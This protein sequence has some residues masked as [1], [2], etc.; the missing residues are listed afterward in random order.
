MRHSLR[1]ALVVTWTASLIFT[2]DGWNSALAQETL[3][4]GYSPL[5]AAPFYFAR[6][7]EYLGSGQAVIENRDAHRTLPSA[8]TGPDPELVRHGSG[9][10]TA[11]G[12]ESEDPEIEQTQFQSGR[13]RTAR[14]GSAPLSRPALSS[15]ARRSRDLVRSG[16]STSGLRAAARTSGTDRISGRESTFRATTDAGSLLGRS[17]RSRNISTQQRNP[18]IND[19]R[20]RGTRTGQLLA[21]GSFWVPA[22]VDL[23]TMLSKLDSRV[24]DDI[25]VIKGPYSALYGPGLSFIDID[26]T[27]SRRSETGVESG[28]M[29]SL[30]Y[31]TN[32]E[33]WYGRQE[34]WVAG[35]NSGAT[36]SYGHR[37]G[38][39]YS[40]GSSSER[41]PSSYNS[42]DVN[43]AAGVDLDERRSLEF[44][45]IR[46]DQTDVDLAGQIF[47]IDTLETD[48]FEL[49]YTAG[50]GDWY[51]S[52]F[53][54]TW[55]NQ[56]NFQGR[57]NAA[58]AER[59]TPLFNRASFNPDSRTLVN[60]QS[61]GYRTGLNWE[62]D[63]A[64]LTVG[65]DLRFIRQHLDEFT[66]FVAVQNNMPVDPN[67]PVPKSNQL[68]P[69]LFVEASLGTSSATTWT[70]GARADWVRYNLLDSPEGDFGNNGLTLRQ[71]LSGVDSILTG[72]VNNQIGGNIVD[73]NLVEE[74][75]PN[76]VLWSTYLTGTTDHGNGVTTFASAGIGQRPP[77]LTELY[78]DEPF[79]FLVQ[80]G[81]TALRGNPRLKPSTGFQFDIGASIEQPNYRT[82]V[83]GFYSLIEDYITFDSELVLISSTLGFQNVLRSVNSDLAAIGGLELD[84]D[85]D[86]NE[87]VTAFGT[88]A[89]THGTD[90]RRNA[91]NRD[92]TSTLAP[93]T[94]TLPI[95]T[96]TT[97]IVPIGPF[98]VPQ[99]TVVVANKKHEPLPAISPLAARLGLRLHE[100]VEQPRY[101]VELAARVVTAQERVAAS[102]F[103]TPTPG[104]T[105]WDL[106][107]FWRPTPSVLLVAGVE[108]LTDKGYREHLDFRDFLE[109]I[110]VRRPG[111]SYYSSV[112][113]RY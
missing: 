2:G 66:Q 86:V 95:G 106:R 34:L 18:V 97:T 57:A 90:L 79:L 103:E 109:N 110:E 38:S 81:L 21:S 56:T 93:G 42:R 4:P 64:V 17:A 100:P 88:L 11:H 105:V 33:Q 39:D 75:D 41:I 25:V 40:V 89:W 85:V 43:V 71:T 48:G 46:L 91:E 35:E 73:P 77:T 68:N 87:W 72:L 104:F 52:A 61:A 60:S 98:N 20:V 45:Y 28:G 62:A 15:A 50:N 54:T 10:T 111:R 16:R 5:P 96:Q 6:P 47:D 108:N 80:S 12:V 78:A 27:Q 1:T 30:E 22:R 82:S 63:N 102:L 59:F 36:V 55:Y 7:N 13:P 32:G 69:G 37:T 8:L 107:A 58:K 24:I 3:R 65:T 31:K 70:A 53:A 26:M 76:H 49:S 14:P 44:N 67:S 83:T 74:L 101:S 23:D 19:P 112:E 113:I 99:T 92:V 51:D 9:L 29:S 94:D 84:G